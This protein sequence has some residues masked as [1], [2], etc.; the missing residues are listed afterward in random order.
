MP[1]AH[2]QPL[3]PHDVLGVTIP[4]SSH[5]SVGY[6]KGREML[7]PGTLHQDAAAGA[8]TPGLPRSGPEQTPAATEE[9]PAASN[10]TA[11]NQNM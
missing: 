9:E 4:G 10:G 7:S 5:H 6:S 2:C 1:S 3:S 11:R 8:W